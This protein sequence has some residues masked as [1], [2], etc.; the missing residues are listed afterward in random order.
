MVVLILTAAS[1][2]KPTQLCE[3]HATGHE[4]WL[5]HRDSMCLCQHYSMLQIIADLA[6]LLMRV[7]ADHVQ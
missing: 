7:I 1:L 5:L 4:C 2:S 6:W 3:L